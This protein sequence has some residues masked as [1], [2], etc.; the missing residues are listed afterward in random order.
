MLQPSGTTDYFSIRLERILV[1]TDF[2]PTSAMA[3]PYAA[4]IAHRFGSSIYVSHVIHAKEYAHIAADQLDRTLLQMKQAAEQ[5]MKA[6]L[7]SSHFND[8]PFQVILDH[9]DPV[10]VISALVDKYSI[11]LIVAGS[12]GRHG[13]HKLL[14]PSADEAIARAAACPAL[15]IG[16]EAS[17]A[18]EAEMRLKSMLFATDFSP[19]SRR[20]MEYAYALAKAYGA[21]LYIFHVT[22]DV[23]NE[24]LSTRMS[25]D[26]FCRMRLLENG[27]PQ[28]EPGVEPEFLLEFGPSESMI[29]EAAKKRG[30]QLIVV[31]VP[32][33]AHPHLSS[34]LPGP[35]AYN[36][37]SHSLCP[38]LAVRSA[39][40]EK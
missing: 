35:M 11:D 23:W 20:A 16:P 33:T 2:S 12:H 40:Q 27:W 5:Q 32:R 10:A 9:G 17:I 29:L 22:E 13:I 39:A 25:A 37:A 31:G 7:A 8:I 38:V 6:L 15:L 14:S 19:E 30:V 21:N 4:A 36:L 1:A 18:P 24:P 3:L 26:A 34:H 28:S